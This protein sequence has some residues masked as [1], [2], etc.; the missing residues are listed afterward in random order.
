[1]F[2]KLECRKSVRLIV[3][4]YEIREKQITITKYQKALGAGDEIS[5]YCGLT[6]RMQ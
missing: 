5:E 6:P 2:I 4:R 3:M 1:M